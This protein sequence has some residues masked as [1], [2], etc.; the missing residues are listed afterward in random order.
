MAGS[1]N[2][3]MLVGNLGSDPELRSTQAGSKIATLSL[4]TGESWTDKQSG[5]RRERVEWHKVVVFNDQVVGIA[6]RYLR[7]GDKLYVEGALRTRKWTDNDGRDR[8]STEVVI[9][10]FNGA[11]VMLGSPGGRGDGEQR[12]S[13][14][15]REPAPAGAGGGFGAGGGELDDEIPFGPCW[16]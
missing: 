12:H 13:T 8:Y 16:Q 10:R 15:R 7:K 3:V 6:E 11:L 2:K 5:E 9:E 4:A 1:V 14:P